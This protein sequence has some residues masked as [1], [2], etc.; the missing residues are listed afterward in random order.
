[1][2]TFI[3]EGS[4]TS[5][6]YKFGYMEVGFAPMAN[7]ALIRF[8]VSALSPTVKVQSAALSVVIW[9][10]HTMTVGSIGIHQILEAWIDSQTDWGSRQTGVPWTTIGCG[11]GSSSPTVL[12][13]FTPSMVMEYKVPLPASVIQSWVNNPATNFG[14]ALAATPGSNWADF[15]Q[16]G[17]GTNTDPVL[18]VTYTP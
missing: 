14:V 7:V 15:R 8:D 9:Q 13:T 17:V 6:Y 18:A 1:M 2:D 4:P 11:D 16:S 3:S 12:A 5:S 10:S